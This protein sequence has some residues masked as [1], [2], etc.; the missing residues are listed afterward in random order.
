[1]TQ[2]LVP[3]FSFPDPKTTE[4][5]KRR[6]QRAI[7]MIPG[8]LTWTTLLGMVAL[9]FFVPV[10]A[11]IAVIIFDIYWIHKALYISIFSVIGQ[12]EVVEG[13]RINWWDSCENITNPEQ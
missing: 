12:L 5:A 2:S 1:M 10:W 8:L 7:E 4:P 11:A 3:K 6:V 13:S 9:S